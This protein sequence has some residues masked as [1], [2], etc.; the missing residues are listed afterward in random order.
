MI[1]FIEC[2]LKMD[3]NGVNRWESESSVVLQIS[4]PALKILKE[5]MISIIE[6]RGELRSKMKSV[7][8]LRDLEKVE[9]EINP[10]W[11]KLEREGKDRYRKKI[12]KEK[13]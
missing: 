11:E 3:P 5:G 9:R 4:I 1:Q 12:K 8:L 2:V 6:D 10:Q 7:D 13:F